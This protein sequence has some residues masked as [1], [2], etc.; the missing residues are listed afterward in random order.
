MKKQK[1]LT[2]FVVSD[3][4]GETGEMVT[5]AVLS[6]F[7]GKFELRRFSYCLDYERIEKIILEAKQEAAIVAFTLV[8]PELKEDINR[9]AAENGVAIVDILGVFM[10]KVTEVT[11]LKP[12]SEPGLL[13]KL[14]EHYFRKVDAVEFSQKYDDGKDPRGILFADLTLLGVSRTGKTSVAMFLSHKKLRVANILLVPETKPPKEIYEIDR[15]LIFGLTI[16]PEQLYEIRQKRLQ[17]LGLLENSKYAS[18]E[19]IKAELAYAD[20]I[21]DS[22]GCHRLDITNYS[23]ED[24]ATK[25]LDIL[26]KEAYYSE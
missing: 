22:L 21:M 5:K 4:L 26:A 1:K 24:T 13:R 6:Q 20:K 9:L 15:K 19:R 10:Q 14:D 18:L 2:V 3:S 7:K 17:M 12:I 23:V 25:I 16:E 11:G 8:I